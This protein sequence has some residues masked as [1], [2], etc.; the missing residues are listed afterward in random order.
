M[1][2][3]SSTDVVISPVAPAGLGTT[4]VVMVNGASVAVAVFWPPLCSFTTEEEM[5]EASVTG[6]TV[7]VRTTVS[8]TRTVVRSFSG[9]AVGLAGQLVTV[10]AQLVIVRISVAM[11][12][13]VVEGPGAFST[14]A[15]PMGAVPTGAVPMGA[16]AIGAVG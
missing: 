8:V 11:T 9:M 15:V 4:A 2:T 13:I 5:L 3:T 6:H 16:V 14:G 12:V 1:V 7:V 10:G